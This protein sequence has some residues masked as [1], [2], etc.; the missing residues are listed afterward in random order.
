MKDY[1]KEIKMILNIQVIFGWLLSLFGAIAVV[2]L[3]ID[4]VHEFMLAKFIMFLV[5][6]FIPFLGYFMVVEGRKEKETL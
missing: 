5:V 2:S 3:S 1:N 6:L 4:L